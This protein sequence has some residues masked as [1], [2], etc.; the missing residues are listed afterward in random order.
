MGHKH[1]FKSNVGEDIAFIVEYI[2]EKLKTDDVLCE[3]LLYMLT[4]D[5]GWY[6]H[7]LPPN[8]E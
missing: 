3:R 6:L 2:I 4:H 1:E 8:T 7:G 5:R